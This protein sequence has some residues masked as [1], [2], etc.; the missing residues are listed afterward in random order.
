MTIYYYREVEIVYV[1][2]FQTIIYFEAHSH[3]VEINNYNTSYSLNFEQFM[4]GTSR[5]HIN[6]N[7]HDLLHY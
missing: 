2:N 5:V 1:Y 4:T 7:P 3:R 6:I